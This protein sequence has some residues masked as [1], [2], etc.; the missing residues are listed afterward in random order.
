MRVIV[1]LGLM[2]IIPA[3]L[4]S[5]STGSITGTVMHKVKPIEGAT[6]RLGIG[7]NF[8]NAPETRTDA[9]GKF[10]FVNL[11]PETYTV[12]AHFN[13]DDVRLHRLCEDHL[14][15]ETIV[16]VTI[17]PSP[18][19]SLE[20][21]PV[22]M[23]A[24]AGIRE[25]VTVSADVD[26]RPEEVSKT[27]NL[28]GGQE[29]RDRADFAFVDTVRSIPG[30]RVQQLGGF[31]RT[32]SI[33]S[34]GLR[35]QDT[36]VLIDGIRF[37]DP[38]SIT[39][40]A[41]PFLSDITLTS[42]SR[43]EVL[44]GSGSSL[45]GTNAVG[46]TIDFQTP[47]ANSGV[48]GQVSGAAGGLGLGRFRG[49]LS[50]GADKFGI[51]GGVSRT[52]YTKGIDG[53]DN[54][55]NTNLQTRAD[56][57]PSTS[58]DISVRLFASD[59]KVR[60]NSSPDTFGPLPPATTIIDAREGV[61]FVTDV[62]DPDSIQDARFIAGQFSATHAFGDEFVLSGN[63]QTLVAK[64]TNNDGPL[65]VGFQSAFTSSFGGTIN[66][67][68]VRATWTPNYAN[69]LI[70][71]YEFE[72]ER[73]RNE[74]STPAGT[75]DFWTRAGQSSNT[76]Y[77]QHLVSVLDGDL[78]FAAGAR[79]QWFSLSR[80]E[81]S[82]TDGPYANRAFDDPPE[83]YT[84]DGSA[85]YFISQTRTKLRAHAGNGYR[86]PSLYERFGT[87][88]FLGQFS[89]QGNPELKP[90]RSIGIDAGVDQY[91]A[92]RKVKA[93]ATWF[94]T[95]IKDEITYLPT[96]DF[97]YYNFD[98]H[99]SR[100]AEFSI[101]LKPVDSTDIFVSYTFTNSDVRNFRRPSIV[102]VASADRRSFGIP[103]HQFTL[104]A[105]HRIERFW[106]NFD[107][108]ATSSY[109]APVFSNTMFNQ[110]SYRFTGNRR[111]DLTAG[112]TFFLRSGL[113]NVRVFGT[114]ENLFDNKYFENGFR[115]PGR[116]GRAGISLGF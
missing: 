21:V 74:G 46:G 114:V 32:A 27:V 97:A 26:Q 23:S 93:S 47:R 72:S 64:R 102:T 69:T 11:A 84:F 34:R 53:E 54:A 66:T 16:T 91:F 18:Y 58:T 2:L 86:V 7:R 98:R 85:S 10:S 35:N 39:G 45:Y 6:V 4:Y 88:F 25:T 38:G 113:V 51:G 115:T 112:Y 101:D 31:G 5:Q 24:S 103:E 22:C 100:G 9:A 79:A 57:K 71:G 87:F 67:S 68:N 36:A 12:S 92:G 111:G 40:D 59:A 56:F 55:S 44:R 30:F 52:A 61:N 37:R 73:F 96:D 107:L 77:A 116:N 76:V 94:Y 89:P 15:A 70:A 41:T 28:I 1:V 83:A 80:P 60:L 62:N 8:V 78:Q 104:V 110:Y 42:V 29:M 99:Y 105:T 17:G 50:Y 48:H 106:I 95:R 108:L 65:G 90:E 109:L 3:A 19:L 81:F 49:N 63:H 75:T 20:L 13:L 82:S 33:K 14:E 43:I